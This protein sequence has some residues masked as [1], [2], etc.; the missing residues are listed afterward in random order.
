MPWRCFRLARDWDVAQL[1]ERQVQCTADT[2]STA[3]FDKGFFSQSQL[4]VQTFLQCLFSGYLVSWRFKPSQP[5]RIIS[6]RTETFITRYV[7]D[8]TNKAEIR[9]EEQSE[10]AESCRE[11]LWNEI[12]QKGP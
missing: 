1:V 2:V 5:Q 11:N 7:V 10:R 4:L 8:R 6:G 9:P 12:Q 3:R